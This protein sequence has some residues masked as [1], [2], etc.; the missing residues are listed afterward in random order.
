M[1]EE[2]KPEPWLSV[3][4]I[5]EYLSVKPDTIYKWISRKEFPA[6]KAG[7][8]WRFRASEVDSWVKNSSQIAHGERR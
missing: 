3:D 2:V 7:K 6:H 5:A 8:L 1:P 4:D